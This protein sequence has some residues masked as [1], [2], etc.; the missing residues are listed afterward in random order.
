MGVVVDFANSNGGTLTIQR[1]AAQP[2]VDESTPWVDP[3][4]LIT[5]PV[6]PEKYFEITTDI[7]GEFLTDIGFDYT[8]LPGI[9]DPLS[10]RLAKRCS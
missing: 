7:E 3:D 1:I 2:P 10:L 9:E 5:D 6:F 4:G 8:V